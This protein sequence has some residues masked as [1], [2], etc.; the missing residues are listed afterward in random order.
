[1]PKRRGELYRPI[2]RQRSLCAALEEE[3]ALSLERALLGGDVLCVCKH[4][5]RECGPRRTGGE[6]AAAHQLAQAAQQT[7]AD[8]L[9]CH[10][11]K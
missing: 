10:V 5:S 8:K 6:A 9:A 7:K 3:E 1:M 2:A 4:V 11:H